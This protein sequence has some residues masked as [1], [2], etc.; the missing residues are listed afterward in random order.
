MLMLNNKVK[1]QGQPWQ[2]SHVTLWALY[3]PQ[4]MTNPHVA[5]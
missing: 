5:Y 3:K 2:S 1:C 4:F